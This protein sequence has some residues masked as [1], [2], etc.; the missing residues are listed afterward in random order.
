[1]F[2]EDS[3]QNILALAK[4][5]NKLIFID[6]YTT[7]CAPCKWMDKY[8]FINKDVASYYNKNFI[9]VKLDMEKGE[10]L[11]LRDTYGVKSFPT[12]LYLNAEGE[13]VH[14]SGSKMSVERFIEEGRNALNPKKAIGLLA[15][16]YEKGFL[17]LD[18]KVQYAIMLKGADGAKS[19]KVLNEIYSEVDSNYMQ[20]YSG[21][22][23]I[24]A[25]TDNNQSNL[26]KT[27][28][29]NKKHYT[30]MA[31][32][33]SVNKIY[34]RVLL[35]DIYSNLEEK[36]SL[37]FF[38]KLDSLKNVSLNSRT[39][40]ILHCDYYL[41]NMDPENFIKTSN[42]YVDNDLKNDPETIAFIARSATRYSQPLNHKVLEQASVLITKAYR[43]E[44]PSYGTV[45]TYADIQNKIGN[46][47][48]AIRAGE[49]AVKMA[50][51]ISSKIKKIAEKNLQDMQ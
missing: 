51:T 44:S 23:I 36:D 17:N 12:Y 14:K 32:I 50:D 35:N 22:K 24:E 42:Y 11:K 3:F 19:K 16:N 26:F 37:L 38:S 45:S 1:M 31:G 25:F 18:D 48:E 4:K 33:E 47:E 7:W 13:L 5:E 49:L 39:V 46:K 34:E 40:P 8:V 43:T 15:K 41:R 27:L 28:N 2:H 30:E 9:N 20:T 10:G 29:N 21:W 6:C